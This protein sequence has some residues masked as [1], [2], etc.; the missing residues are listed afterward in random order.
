MGD[1]AMDELAAAR[2]ITRDQAY[3]LATKYVPMRRPATA[4]E[5][6]ACALF[7]ASDEASIVTGTALVADGGGLAVDVAEI[8]WGTLDG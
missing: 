1:A 3:Q 2:G 5:I 4:E 7:L 6:A 8:A